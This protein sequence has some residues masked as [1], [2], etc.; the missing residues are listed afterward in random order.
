MTTKLPMKF[1]CILVS[2]L[3]LFACNTDDDASPA[4]ILIIEKNGIE[5]NVTEFQNTLI[6]QVQF[7][8]PGRILEF[9]CTIEDGIFRVNTQ[10]WDWQNPPENGIVIKTYDANYSPG[11]NTDCNHEGNYTYCD[12]GKG[13]YIINNDLIY[14]TDH[15]ENDVP[16]VIIISE[17]DQQDK[18]V[19]GSF[20]FNTF[21]PEAGESIVFKG[22]FENLK[23]VVETR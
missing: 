18:T 23:Y 11:P 1:P 15:P 19:S 12:I 2:F 22:S 3:F 5:Y 13:F 21:S 7:S 16:G 6:K 20:E 10:N 14:R 17:N 4:P 8:R 9:S